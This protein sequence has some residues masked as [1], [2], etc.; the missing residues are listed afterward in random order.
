M[1]EPSKPPRKRRQPRKVTRQSLHNAALHYLERYASSADNLRRVLMRRVRRSALV[2]DTDP[3]EGAR[4]IDELVTR[5]EAAGLLDDRAYAAAR[6]TSLRRRGASSRAIAMGLRQKGVAAPDIAAALAEHEAE[7][8]NEDLEFIAACR[9]AQRRRLGPFRP[10]D[11]VGDFRQRDLAA[12][13]RAGF[14]Y[15]IARR[16][17]DHDTAADLAELIAKANL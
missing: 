8:E 2:H 6:V 4:L 7:V 11:K 16:V 10:P 17:I 13:A 5:F 12:L 15:D 9:L 1:S 3:E 14:A